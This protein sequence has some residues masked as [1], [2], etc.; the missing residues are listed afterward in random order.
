MA[1]IDRHPGGRWRARWRTPDGRSRS[2]V[3]SRKIDAERHLITLERAKLVGAYVD[4]AAGKT[5][6]ADFWA[7]WSERQPWRDRTRETVT[8]IFNRHVLPAFGD[9][10]VGESAARRDRDV[11]G[12]AAVG[13]GHGHQH[14]PVVL[15]AARGR[16]RR[17]SHRCQPGP[18]RQVAP[19]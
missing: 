7:G 18:G 11:G 14:G 12:P 13:A 17:R 1:S 19:G 2:Q 8:S 9:R 3:F 6:V 10:G 5:T 15:D 16:G 4:P